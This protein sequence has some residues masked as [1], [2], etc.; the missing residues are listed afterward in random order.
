MS[1]WRQGP[2]VLALIR[3]IH[4]LQHKT[5]ELMASLTRPLP[6][7][8]ALSAEE[9]TCLWVIACKKRAVSLCKFGWTAHVVVGM[10]KTDTAHGGPHALFSSSLSADMQRLWAEQATLRRMEHMLLICWHAKAVGR[11]SYTTWNGTH[12]PH[13][14]DGAS[15]PKHTVNSCLPVLPAQPL[16]FPFWTVAPVA[17]GALLHPEHIKC[18]CCGIL[19]QNRFVNTLTTHETWNCCGLAARFLSNASFTYSAT[20]NAVKWAMMDMTTT[21][22]TMCQWFLAHSDTGGQPFELKHFLTICRSILWYPL[23]LNMSCIPIQSIDAAS[24]Y[25]MHSRRVHWCGM[26]DG[27]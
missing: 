24:S 23:Y 7:C 1:F 2:P 22:A 9:C 18:C 10:C 14:L 11:A 20:S 12:A 27:H 3:C 19:K 5:Q 21:T 6:W 4:T 8:H 26:L 25:V 13:L 15:A 16:L 17:S